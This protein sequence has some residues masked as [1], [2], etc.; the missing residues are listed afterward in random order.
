MKGEKINEV[1]GT[2]LVEGFRIQERFEQFNGWRQ[3]LLCF[4]FIA[5]LEYLTVSAFRN[6]TL[7]PN[8]Y[9]RKQLP[10]GS[11][12]DSSDKVTGRKITPA[13]S[14]LCCCCRLSCG[15]AKFKRWGNINSCSEVQLLPCFCAWHMF[16]SFHARTHDAGHWVI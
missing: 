3:S 1:G 8:P 10:R 5:S 4:L 15:Q 11:G 14:L 6:A 9:E 2:R 7:I 13:E 12:K 16:I